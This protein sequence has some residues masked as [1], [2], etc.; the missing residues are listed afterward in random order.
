MVSTLMGWSQPTQVL[1]KKSVKADP[2]CLLCV[3]EPSCS[4]S[5]FPFLHLKRETEIPCPYRAWLKI[6]ADISGLQRSY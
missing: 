3:G 1:N 4:L 6:D 2:S 5:G